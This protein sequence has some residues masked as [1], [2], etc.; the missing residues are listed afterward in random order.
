MDPDLRRDIIVA[1]NDLLV[2]DVV[3]IPL[4]HTAQIS[5]VSRTLEGVELTPWDTDTWRIMDWRRSSE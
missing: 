2:E 1:M 5:G 4:V 3:M